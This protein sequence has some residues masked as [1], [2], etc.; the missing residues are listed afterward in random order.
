MDRVEAAI[1]ERVARLVE[2]I[3]AHG[4]ELLSPMQP[5]RRAGIITFRVPGVDQQALYKALMQRGLMC[6]SRG[7]GLRFSPHFYTPMEHLE[8][9]LRLT[10]DVAATLPSHAAV[11][12]PE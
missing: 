12:G 9:A 1:A 11:S 10:L 5:E 8:R 2:L 4:L 7:G 3:D 6:A